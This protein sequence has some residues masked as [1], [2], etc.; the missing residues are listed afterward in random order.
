M[1]FDDKLK[2]RENEAIA[3]LSN[4]DK[5]IYFNI[6]RYNQFK[7]DEKFTLHIA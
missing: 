7:D 4:D 6:M 3:F 5:N 2:L 1:Q